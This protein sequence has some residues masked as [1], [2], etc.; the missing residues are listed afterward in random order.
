MFE[1]HD[2]SR[3]WFLHLFASLGHV[4]CQSK[5]TNWERKPLYCT[6]SRYHRHRHY[7][8]DSRI[9]WAYGDDFFG[10]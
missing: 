3:N 9:S 1:H 5:L 2:G 10:D 4:R 7:D 8:A 6:L